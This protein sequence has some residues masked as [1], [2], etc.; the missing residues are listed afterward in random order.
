MGVGDMNGAT[1]YYGTYTAFN[2]SNIFPMLLNTPDFHSVSVRT[3]NGA[4]AQNKGMALFPRR[5]NGHYAMC[6]RIDGRNLFLMFSDYIHTWETAQRL[7]VPE[8]A[9]DYR[10]IGNCG[11]PLETP[12]GW[13]LITHGVGPMRQ[14]GISAMLLDRHDP[15]IVRGR[16]KEP[17]IVSTESEREGYVPNVVYSCGSLICNQLLILPYAISDRKT[18]VA[19][20]DLAALL[21]KLLASGQ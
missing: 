12:E 8:Y 18:A 3:L 14:Y 17:L 5:I 10:L 1:E 11:S 20:I 19:E 6:S 2:G 4:C 21:Q 7:A 13:L 15:S 9:W 16:L